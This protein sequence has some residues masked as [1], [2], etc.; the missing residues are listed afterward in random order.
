MDTLKQSNSVCINTEKVIDKKRD[1]KAYKLTVIK[2]IFN[3]IFSL[4]DGEI[5]NITDSDDKAVKKSERFIKKIKKKLV[6]VQKKVA[7]VSRKRKTPITSENSGFLKP[8]KVS[9]ELSKFA[10]WE[11]DVPKSRVDVTK[12]MCEYIKKNGLQNP[13]DRRQIIADENLKKLL[14]YDPKKNEPLTYYRIQTY[15]KPHFIK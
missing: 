1:K 2:E 13:T 4:I 7:P 6:A 9:K 5:E 12:Y 14:G 11:P 8:V 15:L 3:D 10:S